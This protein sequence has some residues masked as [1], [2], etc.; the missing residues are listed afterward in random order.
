MKVF[1]CYLQSGMLVLQCKNEGFI[2]V[3]INVQILQTY[4][5]YQ[6]FYSPHKLCT[7]SY[8]SD[9]ET[10]DRTDTTTTKLYL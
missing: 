4:L 2:G 9:R 6:G 7:S 5:F 10:N 1:I 8:Y 3:N